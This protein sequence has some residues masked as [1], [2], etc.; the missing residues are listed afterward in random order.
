MKTLAASTTLMGAALVLLGAPGLAP[1]VTPRAAPVEA[2]TAPDAPVLDSNAPVPDSDAHAL[3][4]DVRVVDQAVVDEYCVR[5]HN[6][7]RLRGNLSLEGFDVT[8]PHEMSATTEKMIVKLRAG[9]MP[10]PGAARPDESALTDLVEG[11]EERMDRVARDRRDPGGRTFQRL[12]RAEYARSIESLLGLTIDPGTY[13]PLDTKSENFDN[14]AD[15]QMLSPTLLD[16]YLTAAADIARLAVGDLEAGNR[17][18]TYSVSGYQ[19]QARRVEGAPYGTRGGTSVVHNFPADGDYVFTIVF[20]HTTTGAGF[21][22][23]LARGEQVEISI[24]GVRVALLDVDA[25]LSYSD[26]WGISMRTEPIA[27]RAGPRRV[28]AAFLTTAEGP[29]EDLLSPHDWSIADRHTGMGGY[30]LTLLPHLRD[31]VIGGPGRVTGVS[32]HPVRERIFTCRPTSAAEERPCAER[33]VR[34]LAAE[35][36]RRPLE[37]RDIEGLMGFYDEGTGAGGFE[38]GVRT[39]LQAILASPHFV[40]RFERGR[41]LDEGVYELGDHALA[42]RLSFFLWALPPDDELRSLADERRLGDDDVLRD[43]VRRM[44][45]D[46]RAEALG[47]RFAGQWLR[48]QDLEKV[49]PD[50]YWFPDYDQ[51]LADAMRRETEHFFTNLVRDDRSIFDL[52]TADYSFMNERLAKHYGIEGVRGEAFRRVDYPDERRR[53]VL[54]HG[55]VLTLTSH[56]DRTSPVLRGKWVME[57]LMGTPPPP[58]PPGVPDLEETEGAVDGR[59]LSTRERMEA[60]R[61]NPTCNS[62]H[63]FID[64]IG[65]ALDG[66][67]VTGRW[68]IREHGAPIDTRGELYDGT[69]I[70]SPGALVD[71]LLRRPEP[72]L[73]TFTANLMAYGLGRRVET[74]DQPTIRAIVREAAGEDHR[75]SSFVLGVVMS[76]AFRIQSTAAI[77]SETSGPDGGIEEPTTGRER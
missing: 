1:G 70:D 74:T 59:A 53:G 30:G 48:L 9:M 6:E 33:I 36:Y 75:V 26:P 24:D 56:A 14:I 66:Y 5:C 39:A 10:P 52:Y 42:S 12:N 41:A 69:P 15:V 57:V 19:S 68:R 18:H 71:A 72:L 37:P 7:R 77:T 17:E 4:S 73:R 11:L 20:E 50:S 60:H 13:L 65:L 54:G 3:Q 61:A 46:P 64:P 16:A 34:R 43:Q 25:W 22:G 51:Q 67:D 2:R 35:A 21:A 45:A 58:P 38:V 31:L 8:R 49:H 76:D 55:S 28:T 40:F 44:L 27:V 47:S 29:A 62:C 23:Q 63:R 32:E